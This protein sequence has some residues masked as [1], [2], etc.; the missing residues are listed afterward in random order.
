MRVKM[1]RPDGFVSNL[2]EPQTAS[3]ILEVQELFTTLAQWND[4]LEK[5]APYFQRGPKL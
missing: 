4:I 1:V 3:E 2:K 5:D